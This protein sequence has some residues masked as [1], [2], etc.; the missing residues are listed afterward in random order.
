MGLKCMRTLLLGCMVA[1]IGAW[2]AAC[3]IPTICTASLEFGMSIYVRDS[4]SGAGLA[5]GSTVIVRDGSLLIDSLETTFPSSSDGPFPSAGERAG[6][7]TVT[8]LHNGF[9]T[10]TKSG[11][12][13]TRGTCHVNHID[14]I[15][16]LQP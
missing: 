16:R 4:A 6:T 2:G 7:Y 12:V 13:V 1:A 9:Q 11:V 15:V 5:N 10:W 14:V 3:N 8:V